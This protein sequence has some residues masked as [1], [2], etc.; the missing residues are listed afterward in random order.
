M[1][2]DPDEL[3]DIVD[4]ADRVV[5]QERRAVVHRGNLLHRAVH[6]W[7]FNGRGELLLQMR[8]ASK[9]QYPST[10]TSSAS[11]HLDAGES[12]ADAAP[13]ELREELGVDVPLRELLKLPAA[14][15]TAYEFTTLFVGCFD[16]RPSPAADEVAGLRWWRP[17]DLREAVRDT[18]EDFSPPLRSLLFATDFG[19]D[20]AD[21]IPAC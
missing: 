2:T 6:V 9:D 21:I 12:Y 15:E 3:F 7:L 14:P 10:W 8:S 4:E 20:A 11:G 5:R 17:A 13:R 19:R 16:G 1:R 18:P